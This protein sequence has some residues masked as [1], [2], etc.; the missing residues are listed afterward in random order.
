MAHLVSYIYIFSAALFILSLKWMNSPV[1]ARRSVLA[2]EIGMLMAIAGT[3]LAFKVFNWE[4]ILAAFFIG[5]SRCRSGP[6]CPT[7]AGRWP[8]R[9]WE[10]PNFTGPTSSMRFCPPS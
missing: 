1:T 9:W 7:P 8:P 3:L 4:W 5:T 6:R 10:R 2:G